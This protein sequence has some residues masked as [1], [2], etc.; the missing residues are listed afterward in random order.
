M[1]SIYETENFEECATLQAANTILQREY[2]VLATQKQF[3]QASLEDQGR[4][5]TGLVDTFTLEAYKKIQ[6]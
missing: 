6:R 5:V 1:E 3:L 4:A 2:S